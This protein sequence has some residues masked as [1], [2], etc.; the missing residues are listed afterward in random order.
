MEPVIVLSFANDKGRYLDT[1]AMERDSIF[2]ALRDA[3]DNHYVNVQVEFQTTLEK[4]CDTIDRYAKSM[5]IL[6][7][8]GHAD[9]AMLDLEAPGGGNAPAY[10]LGLAK[11]IGEAATCH[12]QLKLVFLNGCATKAQVQALIEN[13]VPAVIATAAPIE[14]A[15]AADFAT[16]FYQAFAQGR[17]IGHAFAQARA[18][19]EAKKGARIAFDDHR[20][21]TIGPGAGVPA[22][23]GVDKW[24][25][26]VAAGKA[27]VLEWV[28]PQQSAT[29]IIVRGS[30]APSARG[31][32]VNEDLILALFQAIAPFDSDTGDLFEAYRKSGKFDLR[33]VRRAITDAFPIPIGEQ[34]R[35]LFA[36]DTVNEARLRQLLTTYDIATKLVAFALLSQLWDVVVHRPDLVIDARH[37]TA[38]EAFLALDETGLVQFDNLALAIT[39]V[40]ILKAN[41]ALPFMHECSALAQAFSSGAGALAQRFMPEMKA[42]LASGTFDTREIASFCSQA[43]DH[44]MAVL[45]RLAFVASYKLATIKTIAVLTSRH[46]SPIFQHTQVTLDRATDSPQEESAEHANFTANQAVILLKNTDDVSQY[47]DL[48]PFLI[49]QNALS[50]DDGSQLYVFAWH[51]RD[52]GVCHF[53]SIY[54][55]GDRLEISTEDALL[56][57]NVKRPE[58]FVEMRDLMLRFEGMILPPPVTVV[59]P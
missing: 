7:Y 2:K 25:L 20:G 23:V 22:P 17:S 4:L 18:V 34:V 58:R 6:H 11:L 43:Q 59:R 51:D 10:A 35:K 28:L 49:D 57:R 13:G 24:G 44:L 9:G 56:D 46:Q 36:S 12:Q 47:L 1:L 33:K 31:K 32:D 39:V 37:R 48:T 14:D 19:V 3:N 55:D 21:I 38:I 42:E 29:Q 52:G 53:T 27:E 8:A 30:V 15:I 16:A 26:Y 40:D 5:A 50:E 54:N 41:A 45:P